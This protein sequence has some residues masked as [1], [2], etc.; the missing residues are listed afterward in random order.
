MIK[1]VL[2]IAKRESGDKSPINFQLPTEKKKE[3][4][5]LCRQYGISLTAL[6]NG[7][8]DVLIQES[9][10]IY[11][12]IS[13]DAL[14]KLNNRINEINKE[15]SKFK[16]I[17]AGLGENKKLIPDVYLNNYLEGIMEYEEL[18]EEKK[19]IETIFTIQKKR[20]KVEIEDYEIPF[21][22]EGV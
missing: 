17:E 1:T 9:K 16:Y 22:D 21:V 2:D 8:V 11:Q 5:N 7:L 20:Q 13:V 12:E 10:G 15:L 3:L 19:R 14:L 4:D 18:I 6:M